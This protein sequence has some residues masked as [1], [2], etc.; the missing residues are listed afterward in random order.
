MDTTP[1]P[2]I[3]NDPWTEAPAAD[4]KPPI[5]RD[6]RQELAVPPR[7]TD[8]EHVL[9]QAIDDNVNQQVSA[10]S[11]FLNQVNQQQ[12]EHGPLWSLQSFLDHMTNN[13][14]SAPPFPG[15]PQGPWVSMANEAI[16]G[17]EGLAERA[18]WGVYSK[19]RKP[20]DIYVKPGQVT[21]DTKDEVSVGYGY[22]ITGNGIENSRKLFAQIGIDSARFDKIINGE[23]TISPDEALRLREVKIQEMNGYLN[24]LTGNAPLKDNQRAALVSM[25]Y[26]FG[27]GGFKKTGIP[28]LI[29]QG[30]SDQTVANAIANASP[31]QKALQGRRKAEAMLYAGVNGAVQQVA[32]TQSNYLK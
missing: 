27:P 22:N 7:N 12:G 4:G 5:L 15:A 19:N 29:K 14:P 16:G 17:T 9:S 23:G 11:L 8:P 13:T 30:A 18:Y 10:G 2:P 25:V 20:G 26:N 24:N 1:Q 28:D 6:P 32:S 3:L 31:N 21:A